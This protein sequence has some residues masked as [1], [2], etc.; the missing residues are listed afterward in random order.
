MD[1]NKEKIWYI[2][3]YHFDKGDNASQ[4]CEKICGVYG[5][6][7]VSK[8]AARKCFARF[9]SRNF[10]IKDQPRSGRPITEKSDAILEKI[11]QD[12]HI[13]NHDITYELNI[14]HQTVLNH[15]QKAGFKK[16]LDVWGPHELSVKNKMKRLKGH[17]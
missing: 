16:K 17:S 4:A 2:L 6:V 13:S 9:R 5:E 10:N 14:H 11:Q 8:S 3:Q 15:L 7:A 12:R 1:Q